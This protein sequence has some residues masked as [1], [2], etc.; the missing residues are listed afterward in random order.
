MSQNSLKDELAPVLRLLKDLNGTFTFADDE[1]NVFELARKREQ[2]AASPVVAGEQ[3]LPLLSSHAVEAAVRQHAPELADDVI[4]AINRDIALSQAN[5][6]IDVQEDDLALPF[7][8][9]NV[10]KVRFEPLKGDLPPE[11]QD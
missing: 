5:E 1:G 6:E 8:D 2:V 9:E 4:E 3:Q 11:L 7:E 10:Q